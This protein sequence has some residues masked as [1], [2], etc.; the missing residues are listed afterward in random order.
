MP[1]D[2]TDEDKET[3]D[4][5][6]SESSLFCNIYEDIGIETEYYQILAGEK[7]SAVAVRIPRNDGKARIKEI[8]IKDAGYDI[9]GL[10]IGVSLGE[11]EKKMNEKGFISE[12]SIESEAFRKGN[13]YI[14]VSCDKNDKI[15]RIFINLL[16]D[17][18]EWRGIE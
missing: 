5:L 14:S 4:E 3:V 7:S 10:G 13:V 9:Y 8:E 6:N 17:Y 2:L 11:F 15:Q 12:A 16:V 18:Q 1:K